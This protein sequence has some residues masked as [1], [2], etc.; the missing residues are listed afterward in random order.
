VFS[1]GPI[2]NFAAT[3]QDQL[4]FSLEKKQKSL[5]DEFD[6]DEPQAKPPTAQPTHQQVTTAP[7]T[8]QSTSSTSTSQLH[9]SSS[10]SANSHSP[11]SVQPT[12]SQPPRS[13]PVPVKPKP[14]D[15]FDDDDDDFFKREKLDTTTFFVSAKKPVV[16]SGFQTVFETIE[17]APIDPNLFSVETE[18]RII[19]MSFI[20]L[21]HLYLSMYL[22]YCIVLNIVLLN[23]FFFLTL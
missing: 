23:N 11:V 17:K 8:T 19:L 10:S 6:D 1:P 9:P 2:A 22:S 12:P 7:S 4:F 16:P 15:A 3:A 5:F 20:C 13:Q 18:V 21:L 14:K